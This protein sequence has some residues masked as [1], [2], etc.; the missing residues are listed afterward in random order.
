[1]IHLWRGPAEIDY[2]L[3]LTGERILHG[4]L[5]NDPVSLKFLKEF[6]RRCESRKCEKIL[7]W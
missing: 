2:F 4:V 5:P 6:K 1:M 7:D 3:K